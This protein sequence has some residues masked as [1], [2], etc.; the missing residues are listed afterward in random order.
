MWEKINLLKV[1]GSGNV[2]ERVEIKV[3]GTRISQHMHQRP[4]CTI[5]HY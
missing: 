4:T 1:A 5:R 3:T 2:V